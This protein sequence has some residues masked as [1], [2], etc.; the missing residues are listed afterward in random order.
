MSSD[1]GGW[2]G[3]GEGETNTHSHLFTVEQRLMLQHTDSKYS[4]LRTLSGY[5]AQMY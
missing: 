4:G 3:E 2:R 5:F 1:W